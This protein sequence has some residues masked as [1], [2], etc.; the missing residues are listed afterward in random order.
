MPFIRHTRDK[1]GYESLVVLHAYRPGGHDGGRARVLYLYRSPAH[2]KL[3]RRPLE[4]E[5]MDALE[6][7]HPDLSFDWTSLQKDAAVSRAD[8]PE[9]PGRSANYRGSRPGVRPTPVPPAPP[10]PAVPRDDTPLGRALG[11]AEAARLRQR[12]RE[13]QQR[14]E[15][16]ARTPEERD[17][18]TAR[19]VRLNP[20]DWA[21]ESAVRSGARAV[22]AEW[23]AIMADL[24]SRRRGRRGGRRRG[25]ASDEEDRTATAVPAGPA[26]GHEPDPDAP[27]SLA[28]EGSGIM[29]GGEDTDAGQE[30][31]HMDRPN[32]DAD[33]SG[34]RDRVG[35][36]APSPAAD[37]D[38][39]GDD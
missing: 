27:A 6:S 37:A 11:G 21:D 17:R 13:L 30:L 32:R 15:R 29:D 33:G 16:R 19:L 28:G 12:Y 9:L 26:D 23:G 25:Q 38:L 14:V 31:A 22:D 24:P 1:R 35:A 20:D 36:N 34:D 8:H 7:T 2:L 39:P 3:G 4:P 10:A 5:V 18:L